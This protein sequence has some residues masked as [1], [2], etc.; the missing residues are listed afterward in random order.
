M[1]LLSCEN[2]LKQLK[3]LCHAYANRFGGPKS[4]FPTATGGA[5]WLTLAHTKPPLVDNTDI[6]KCPSNPF[7]SD[8]DS[9][10]YLGPAGDANSLKPTDILGGCRHETGP[11]EAVYILIRKDS[12]VLRLSEK[13]ANP[14]LSQLKK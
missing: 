11:N 12:E 13:D 9:T 7:P 2:N 3:T 1:P 10:D 8:V 5:F 14:Y 4:Q 6:F